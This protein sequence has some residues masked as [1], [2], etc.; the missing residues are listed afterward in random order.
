MIVADPIEK[1][2]AM[3]IVF[4]VVA[5]NGI[6]LTTCNDYQTAE[7]FCWEH[8]PVASEE[9]QVQKRWVPK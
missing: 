3:K 4:K 7:K 1:P 8:A 2:S 5:D 9:L 6:V